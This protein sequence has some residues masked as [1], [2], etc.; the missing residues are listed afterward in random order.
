MSN[1]NETITSLHDL[2]DFD[3]QR[4]LC[5]EVQLKN[6]L[7]QW[8]KVSN[9]LKL[10]SIL[11]HY[12]EMVEDHINKLEMFFEAEKINSVTITNRIMQALIEETEEKIKRSTDAQIQDAALLAAV[13]IINH[14]KISTYGTSAAFSK[15]LDNKKYGEIFLDAEVNEKQIDERLS[16]LAEKEINLDAKAPILLHS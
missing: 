8:I 3:A 13:Q 15:A 2:L 12:L 14:F 5:A 4:Y 10:K 6:I 11:N 9:S 16:M 7:P 1:N